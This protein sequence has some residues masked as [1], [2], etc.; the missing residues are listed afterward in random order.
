MRQRLRRL[1]LSQSSKARRAALLREKRLRKGRRALSRYEPYE[2][3]REFHAAGRSF[4]E[5]LLI[6]G[7]QQ[8]KSF[9]GGAE[10]AMHATGLYPEWWEGKRFDKPILI[11]TGSE[12][13]ET[14]KEIIQKML[15]GTSEPNKEAPEFGTGAIPGESIVS[16]TTRQAG[17]K[18]V[19]DEIIVRHVSGGNSRIALK[20]YEQG[21]AKW[22]GAAVHVVW[23]DEEPDANIY[24][25]GVTRTN[26]TDGITFMTFTP[27]KGMSTVAKMFLQPEPGDRPRHATT[28]TI[29]DAKHYSSDEIEDIISSYPEHER[30]TR[31]YGVPMMGEGLVWPVSDKDIVC[32][33]VEIPAHW[34]RIAGCD[35]GIDHPAAGAWLAHDRDTDTVYLYDCYSKSDQGV[36]Y[37]A[38]AFK[39]RDPQ[40]F[41]RVAWPHDGLKRDNK[42]PKS[43]N[44]M[45][46]AYKKHGVNMMRDSARYEPE[47]G[48]AQAVEPVVQDIYERMTTGR[49]KVFSTCQKFF[50]E[51][52][53]F[54]RKD[55]V[56]VAKGED[57]ISATRMAMIELRSARTNVPRRVARPAY[58]KPIA[59]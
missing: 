53:M 4:R 42:D 41:I 14:S 47:T 6:A 31:A 37:H 13:N 59:A 8:G 55:G 39:S 50:E 49:F 25:E 15:L 24:S 34:A 21:R 57:I 26:T 30:D 7:N 23:F 28:M 19:A 9:A 2:K 29:Y 40:G 10:V 16:V 33:P 58:T 51:K 17:V 52:R 43:G 11:W 1:T 36:A 22:Q 5:R 46:N 35:F 3:Q 54:H 18:G 45:K 12:T 32:D 56:I 20:T 48:G 44:N 38:Q 27:L